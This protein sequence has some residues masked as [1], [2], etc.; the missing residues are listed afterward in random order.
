MEV[1]MP[2]GDRTGPLGDGAISGR[3]L[4]VCSGNDLNSGV[5]GRFLGN[6]RGTRGGRCAFGRG[7]WKSMPEN[8]KGEDLIAQI[9]ALKEQVITLT[10]KLGDSDK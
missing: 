7:Y 6:R 1:S 5:A 3:G 9:N 4:G 8:E 10:K 2:G